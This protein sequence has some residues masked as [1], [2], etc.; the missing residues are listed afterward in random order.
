MSSPIFIRRTSCP[1]C[2][3]P[4]RYSSARVQLRL[5]VSG[6]PL[7][8]RGQHDRLF[9]AVQRREEGAVVRGDV[10]DVGAVLETL[11]WLRDNE[12]TVRAA[13]KEKGPDTGP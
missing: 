3:A 13:V 1:A 11:K 8:Q 2:S 7:L 4:F 10:E 6:W 5:S 9:V 12:A